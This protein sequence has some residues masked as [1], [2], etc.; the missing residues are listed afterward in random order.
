MCAIESG[1]LIWCWG[2][3]F[4]GQLGN[5]ERTIFPTPTFPTSLSEFGTWIAAKVNHTCAVVTS[6]AVRCWGNNNSAQLGAA[7]PASSSDP[8]TVLRW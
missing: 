3:N 1:G 2:A 7:T 4:S 6:G 5:P 8:I